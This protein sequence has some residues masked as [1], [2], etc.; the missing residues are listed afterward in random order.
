MRF[1]G[2]ELRRRGR[3]RGTLA[4]GAC[5][6]VGLLAPAAAFA[7]NHLVKLRE[8]YAGSAAH[9]G[10][11]YVEVQLYASG[12]NFFANNI[13]L[14]FYDHSG[15]QTYHFAPTT[16]NGDPPNGQSQRRVLF[17]TATAQTTFSKSA[18]YTLDAGSHIADAGGAVCYVSG[19][20]GFV[21][22]VSW[23]NFNNTSGTPLPSPTG[24]NV[25]PTGI[26]DTKAIRRSIARGCPTWLEG[27][28]D[29]NSPSDWANVTPAPLNNADTPPE[30]QCPNTTITKAPK[31][32][33][34]DRTP[35][36]K[37]KSSQNPATFKCKLDSKP[38]KP[39]TSPDT[40]PR[41]K[42]GKHVFKVRAFAGGTHD[43][44]PATARFKVVRRHR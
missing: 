19:S 35:T 4:V 34:T 5:L 21:D 14:R 23:G 6:V 27:P 40:L 10:D 24:G 26:P 33:T 13:D 29:T 9:P 15:N 3:H 12:E 8:V 25:D 11:E 38:Y 18:G 42:R 30:H 1:A 17:A 43:P 16:L 36:I 22:C 31:R 28:D 44:T 39:C 20:P 7:S 37:F 32:R 2:E 41:L